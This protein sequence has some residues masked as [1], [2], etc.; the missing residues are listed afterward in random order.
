MDY[1]PGS[2]TWANK[3]HIMANRIIECIT[4]PEEL[5]NLYR[6]DKKSFENE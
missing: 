6:S 4:K 3:K 2:I 1:T 5:E